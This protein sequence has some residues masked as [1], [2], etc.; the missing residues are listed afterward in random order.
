[1][2]KMLLRSKV[3]RT[4]SEHL[5]RELNQFFVDNNSPYFDVVDIKII[6]LGTDGN[7]EKVL[8]VIIYNNL[9]ETVNEL[10]K[11]ITK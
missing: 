10:D 1:M 6:S 3:I 8:A 2:I 9:Q 7:R 4:T 5:Q 11:P